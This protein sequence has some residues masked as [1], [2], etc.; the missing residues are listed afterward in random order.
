MMRCLAKCIATYGIG[1][2][3][4]AGEDLPA[5]EDISEEDLAIYDSDIQNAET[6]DQLVN[7]FK[8]ASTKYPRNTEFLTQIR[9]ACGVRKQ[10][11]IEG[12]L[13]G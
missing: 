11:I 10:Q 13:N 3:V 1:L 2:Y 7:I 9:T 6:V 5:E 12:K 4:Y 8:S